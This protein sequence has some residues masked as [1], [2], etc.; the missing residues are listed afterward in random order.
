MH[1][2]SRQHSHGRVCCAAQ[3]RLML[4]RY[5]VGEFEQFGRECLKADRD[6]CF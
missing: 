1:G 3:G 6:V 4:G 5:E 2:K